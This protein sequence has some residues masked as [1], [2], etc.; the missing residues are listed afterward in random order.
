[1][2]PC[3]TCPMNSKKLAS[4]WPST[5]RPSKHTK[6]PCSTL[7]CSR[8]FWG[9]AHWWT[10]KLQHHRISRCGRSTLPSRTQHSPLPH[11]CCPFL[12]HLS[13][14][15]LACLHSGQLRLERCEVRHPSP[16]P[17]V[18]PLTR[19]NSNHH[20][21]IL[22]YPCRTR[23]LDLLLIQEIS[24]RNHTGWRRCRPTSGHRWPPPRGS[25]PLPRA[26]S[27]RYAVRSHDLRSDRQ[28]GKARLAMAHDIRSRL[29][30]CRNDASLHTALR[31]GSTGYNLPC[32]TEAVRC[33]DC[34]GHVDE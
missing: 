6:R 33:H 26:K 30:R 18:P 23:S 2:L 17:R 24:N 13:L 7:K 20:N 19:G 25:P 1:M 11:H 34:G 28:L 21:S 12:L 8:L 14:F 15:R 22:P 27:G 5:D 4:F 29:L 10:P 31:S 3:H 16:S 32:F 9:A